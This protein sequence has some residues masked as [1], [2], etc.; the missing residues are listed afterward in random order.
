MILKSRLNG[1][2][3]AILL[4]ALGLTAMLAYFKFWATLVDLQRSRAGVICLSLKSTIEAATDLGLA[5]AEMGNAQDVIDRARAGDQQILSITVFDQRGE[6]LFFSAAE[7]PGERAP[8]AAAWLALN[9]ASATIWESR[10]ADAFVVGVALLNPFELPIGGVAV[11]L[12]NA[13]LIAKQQAIMAELARITGT[14]FLTM[15]LLVALGVHLVFGGLVRAI[16]RMDN[17]VALLAVT[18]GVPP[19]LAAGTPIEHDFARFGERAAAAQAA[20]SNFEQR[21]REPP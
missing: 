12:S 14:V 7:R 15:S 13:P 3:I 20:L 1:A 11:R 18:P 5:L 21:L 2:I 17:A 16:R 9:E 10:E 8:V 19:A 6:V 4:I